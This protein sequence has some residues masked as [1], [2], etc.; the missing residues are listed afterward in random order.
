MK[1]QAISS[2]HHYIIVG[3][4]LLPGCLQQSRDVVCK[5]ISLPQRS[6]RTCSHHN[7]AYQKALSGA[8]PITIWVHG[9]RFFHHRMFRE[10]FHCPNGLTKI[11]TLEQHHYWRHVL[12][13]L[14]AGN[15]QQYPLKTCYLFGWP[16]RLSFIQREE[17]AQLLYAQLRDVIADYKQQYKCTPYIQV[18]A[19]SHGGNVVLNLAN[20]KKA[21]DQDMIINKLILMACPVQAKTKNLIKDPMF[22]QVYVLY[23][24]LDMIQVM[25]PQGLYKRKQ[26][27]PTSF[28]SKR[29]FPLKENVLQIKMRHNRHAVLHTEFSSPAFVYYLPRIIK[30]IDEWHKN[31]LCNFNPTSETRLMLTV[32]TNGKKVEPAPRQFYRIKSR[33][34]RFLKPET[35]A[36]PPTHKKPTMIPTAVA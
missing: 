25:D 21:E 3:T 26:E 36:A 4:L 13:A 27:T 24:H 35:S 34:K 8:P 22:K 30:E 10:F 9:T 6:S 32:Y 28:F 11:A 17:Y 16:G 19:H 29:R 31:E 15:P 14:S 5:R 1:E 20:T 2:A 23:S 18:I 7:Q 33:G 12:N